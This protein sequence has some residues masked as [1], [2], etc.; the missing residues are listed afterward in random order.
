M[1]VEDIMLSEISRTGNFLNLKKRKIEDGQVSILK[2]KQVV[3]RRVQ[4]M[5][6]AARKYPS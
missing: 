5:E 4:R 1:N 2:P 6:C 3:T